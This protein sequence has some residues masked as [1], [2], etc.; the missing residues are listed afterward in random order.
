MDDTVTHRLE[1]AGISSE[2][3]DSVMA[4]DALFQAWRRRA[5]RR[6]LGHRAIVDLGLPVDLA[7]LDVLVAVHAPSNEF[8]DSAGEETTVGVVAERLGIDPSRASRLVSEMVNAGYASRAASQQDSR[9]TV[10][11]LTPSGE[12]VV[13][14]LR[15]YKFLYMGDFLDGWSETERRTFISLMDR[16]GAWSDA[17]NQGN[18]IRFADEI[19]ALAAE[20]AA[21]LPD[22]KGVGA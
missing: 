11:R 1:K 4:L 6:E 9:R 20:V 2:S 10:I 12:T 19:E 13:T 18:S 7:Q 16:F 14:A 3:V 5:V 8:G 22:K 17:A 15:T 21:S